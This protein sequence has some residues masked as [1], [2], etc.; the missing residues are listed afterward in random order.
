MIRLYS[1]AAIDALLTA[2]R[3]DIA[4]KVAAMIEEMLPLPCKHRD[5]RDLASC[6]RCVK[7]QTV[8]AAARVVRETGGVQ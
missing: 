3:K 8:Q 1:D 4:V 7:R 2:D 5:G 6:V